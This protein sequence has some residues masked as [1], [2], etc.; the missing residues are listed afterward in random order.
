MPHPAAVTL[1]LTV[2]D[3]LGDADSE[4]TSTFDLITD[5][6]HLATFPDLRGKWAK[7]RHAAASVSSAAMEYRGAVVTAWPRGRV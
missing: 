6:D 2:T 7:V 4:T 5:T 3:S 1:G